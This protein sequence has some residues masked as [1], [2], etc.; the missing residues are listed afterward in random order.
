MLGVGPGTRLHARSLQHLAVHQGRR[1]GALRHLSSG[2]RVERSA[3]DPAGVALTT[4]LET[5]ARSQRVALR[6]LNDAMDVLETAEGG[7]SAQLDLVQRAR[8][9]AT[10]AAS[11]TV[12]DR[13]RTVLHEELTALVAEADRVA[14]ATVFGDRAMLTSESVD[15]A[16]AIDAAG[17]YMDVRIARLQNIL[18]DFIE[19]MED[20]GARYA[21]AAF[22]GGLDPLDNV[23]LVTQLGEGDLLDELATLPRSTWGTPDGWSAIAELTGVRAT[24][25]IWDPDAL[26]GPAG[27]SRRILLV[28]TNK[29]RPSPVPGWTLTESQ[30][31][32]AVAATGWEVHVVTGYHNV[33]GRSV[34]EAVYDEVVAATGGSFHSSEQAALD[35]IYAA[36]HDDEAVAVT[37]FRVRAGA[38][39]SAD[40][41]I[42]LDL[43]GATAAASLGLSGL[44]LL[45]RDG[46]GAALDALDAAADTLNGT[47]A[48]IGAVEAR[49]LHASEVTRTAAATA[50]VAASR[51][52]DADLA[53]ETSDLTA[54]TVRADAA[55]AVVAQ[56]LRVQRQ[57]VH[58]LLGGQHGRLFS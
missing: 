22:G 21:L 4:N 33:Y 17:S 10:A 30:L 35:A 5:H 25:G 46:A 53:Q 49:L 41:V 8:E 52:T 47:R 20:V 29:R 9:L 27:A 24:A 18:P 48:R 56:A 13:A 57:Q 26:A 38:A 28:S 37:P 6:N 44:S 40:D 43:P 16:F 12:D 58:A 23:G 45:T 34:Q 7:V 1:L 32:A 50:E 3:D 2:L 15:I 51:I 11:E 14:A 55:R 31:A 54:A 36:T 42:D 39:S 19:D